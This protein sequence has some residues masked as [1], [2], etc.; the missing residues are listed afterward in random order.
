MRGEA[1]GGRGEDGKG[2]EAR[3][4]MEGTEVPWELIFVLGEDLDDL[5]LRGVIAGEVEGMRVLGLGAMP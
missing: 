4:E 2:E 3:G 5:G 1:G